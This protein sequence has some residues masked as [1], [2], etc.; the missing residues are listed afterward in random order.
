MRLCHR[1]SYKSTENR[2]LIL[3]LL[4]RFPSNTASSTR[5]LSTH[6][7]YQMLGDSLNSSDCRVV[8]VA[9]NP[10]DTVVSLWHFE[11]LISLEDREPR[12]LEDVVPKFCAGTVIY[13]PYYEHVLGYHTESLERPEKFFFVAYEELKSDPKTH[14]K[15]LA[16]FLG[17]PFEGGDDMDEQVEEV[18]RSCSVENLKKQ[19]VNNSTDVPSWG[20]MPYKSYFRKGQVGDHANHLTKDMI[21]RIDAITKVKFHGVNLALGRKLNFSID[22]VAS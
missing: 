9:R 3:P 10:K 17:C 15:R 4:V 22:I 12:P 21:D 2:F 8:Y 20:M 13:G 7:P 6:L 16:E 14:V 5:L 18:V 19:E 1:L 11:N